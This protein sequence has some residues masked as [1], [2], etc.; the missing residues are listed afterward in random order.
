MLIFAQVYILGDFDVKYFQ[1]V[2][3][4]IYLDERFLVVEILHSLIHGVVI[5]YYFDSIIN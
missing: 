1:L 2:P 3:A 5:F 4:G